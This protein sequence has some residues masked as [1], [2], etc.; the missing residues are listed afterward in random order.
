M[1][2]DVKITVFTA[3][4]MSVC[5]LAVTYSLW[6]VAKPCVLQKNCLQNHIGNNLWG[7][8]WSRIQ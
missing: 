4:R 5:R 2:S 3:H 6:I 1:N 7:I 8:E